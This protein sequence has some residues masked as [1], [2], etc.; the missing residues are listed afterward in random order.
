MSLGDP[1]RDA[2]IDGDFPLWVGEAFG[3]SGLG[4]AGVALFVQFTA[5]LGLFNWS[6]SFKVPAIWLVITT[7]T[8]ASTL[9]VPVAFRIFGIVTTAVATL[10]V[11]LWLYWSR[12]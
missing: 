5:A 11:G 7:P 8:I 12:T 9:P 6:E 2:L 1:A 4:V 3:A 10:F